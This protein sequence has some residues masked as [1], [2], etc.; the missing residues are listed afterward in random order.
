MKS[1]KWYFYDNGIRNALIAN[2]NGLGLRN[3]VGELWENYLLAERIKY[4]QYTGLI[5]NNY[6]WRTYQQQEI[7][8]VEER[9]GALYAY[10]LKWNA[11][12]KVKVPG[13]WK[14][15]YP[16][17]KFEVITPANYLDWII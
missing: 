13:S 5:V 3:D 1:S 15:A 4:Q 8:W 7:D 12:K 14:D 16:G 6:F 9:G 17:S 11:T 10:E 2:F